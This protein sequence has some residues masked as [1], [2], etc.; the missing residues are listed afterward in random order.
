MS[1][2]YKIRF[3]LQLETN[4]TKRKKRLLTTTNHKKDRMVTVA[5]VVMNERGKWSDQTRPKWCLRP[6]GTRRGTITNDNGKK[7]KP[8]IIILLLKNPAHVHS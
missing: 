7:V 2:K 3:D 5:V 4:S 6:H 8:T 1:N